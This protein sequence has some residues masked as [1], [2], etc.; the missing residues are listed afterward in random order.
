[1]PWLEAIP[2][3]NAQRWIASSGISGKMCF[4]LF[5]KKDLSVHPATLRHSRTYFFH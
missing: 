3:Y 4:P 2:V 1:M 5:P